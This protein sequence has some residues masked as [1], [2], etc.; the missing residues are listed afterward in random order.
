M[1]KKNS[2]SNSKQQYQQIDAKQDQQFF[3]KG[4]YKGAKRTRSGEHDEVSEDIV[5]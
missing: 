2:S 1:W 5:K 4:T 3:T